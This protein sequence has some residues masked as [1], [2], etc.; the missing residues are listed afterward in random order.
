[1]GLELIEVPVKSGADHNWNIR[2]DL[3]ALPKDTELTFSSGVKIQITGLRNPCS[4]LDDFQE[5]LMSAVLAKD[6]SGNLIRKG[7]VMSV[8]LVGGTVKTGDTIGVTLPKEPHL[9]LERV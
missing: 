6:D 4:Q 7:G 8:V 9:K 2:I 3:I 5:G 1:M